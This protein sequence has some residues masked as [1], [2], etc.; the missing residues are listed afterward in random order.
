MIMYSTEGGMEI[1]KVAEE[2]P[3]KYLQKKLILIWV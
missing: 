3:D 2:S 1:E